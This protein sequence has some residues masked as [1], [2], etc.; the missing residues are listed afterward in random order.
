MISIMLRVTDTDD[1]QAAPKVR[2]EL[3]AGV[4]AGGECPT[5]YMSDRGTLVL[6]GDIFD[7]ATAGTE[8]PA[9]EQMIEVPI[10]LL[11]N[12]ARRIN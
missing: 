4:C 3:V 10:E 9:G 8:I 12:Y 7:P 2:L 5:I 6:Q 1:H 11:A